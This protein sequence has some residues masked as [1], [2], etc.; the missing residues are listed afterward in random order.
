MG[1]LKSHH[2]IETVVW[3]AI[4]V[5]L[6]GFSFQFNQPGSI[7]PPGPSAWPRGVLVLMVLAALGNLYFHW[8]NGDSLQEGRI[9]IAVDDETL[10]AERD[11]PAKIRI[12][13]ILLVPFVY[14]MSLKTIGF[15][16]ATPFFIVAVILLMG[17]RRPLPIILNTI[18]IYVIL[19]LFFLVLLNANLPQGTM[20]P[21]YDVSSQF[22]IW[23]TQFHE[24]IGG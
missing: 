21:F 3:L 11:W 14:A 20:R 15:Y 19:I 12:G 17:E 2:I 9:G 1:K 7:Y 24:W 22:L 10:K 13:L 5:I 16:C 23:N 6:F 4:A 18:G 8:K